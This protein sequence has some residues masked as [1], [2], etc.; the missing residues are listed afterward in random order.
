M[1]VVAPSALQRASVPRHRIA[2]LVKPFKSAIGALSYVLMTAT[3]YSVAAYATLASNNHS[4]EASQIAP[5]SSTVSPTEYRQ[6]QDAAHQ[7]MV[8]SLPKISSQLKSETDIAKRIN[9]IEALGNSESELAIT[10]LLNE[11]DNKNE[12]PVAKKVAL[13]SLMAVISCPFYRTSQLN[14]RVENEVIPFI[15]N[16]FQRSDESFRS[17][18]ADILYRMG[19][20]TVAIPYLKA[21]LR[22]GDWGPLNTFIFY[23]HEGSIMR[24]GT[25]PGAPEKR[26]VDLE[27]L[28]ILAEVV[29]SDYPINIKMMAAHILIHDGGDKDIS[30]P[31]LAV[32]VRN[33]AEPAYQMR[34]L[35]LIRDIGDKK[36]KQILLE[37]ANDSKL[38][39]S[40]KA[41]LK[42]LQKRK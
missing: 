24:C 26:R 36:S 19:K 4:E 13:N 23:G 25:F 17:D 38:G 31:F 29:T 33:P 20:K 18:L 30:F 34:A 21:R 9:L 27:A 22:R 35:S 8:D 37:L 15:E 12:S 39:L 28:P 40:A 14:M 42:E 1:W 16:L 2:S 32:T 7:Q 41:M 10:P 11:L 5:E 6:R 3:V